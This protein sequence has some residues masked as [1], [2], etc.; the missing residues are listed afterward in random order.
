MNCLVP[1]LDSIVQ[2]VQQ[3]ITVSTVSSGLDLSFYS[4]LDYRLSILKIKVTYVAQRFSLIW[5]VTSLHNLGKKCSNLKFVL[6]KKNRKEKKTFG[7]VQSKFNSAFCTGALMALLTLR[8]T[9]LLPFFLLI[10]EKMRNEISNLAFLRHLRIWDLK[11][12]H[13]KL[14]IC[15]F[16]TSTPNKFRICD[17]EMCPRIK[18]QRFADKKNKIV[19]LPLEITSAM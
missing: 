17:G 8:P 16:R 6:N 12:N 13:K 19:C 2:Y 10:F 3:F 11:I 9:C 4:C 14:R 5:F 7:S 15:G 1:S 18:D